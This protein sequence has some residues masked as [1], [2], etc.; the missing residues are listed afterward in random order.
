MRDCFV[1]QGGMAFQQIT[2]PQHAG[3]GKSPLVFAVS[4]EL[5]RAAM[6]CG[7]HRRL[8]DAI[9][10]YTIPRI[11]NNFNRIWVRKNGE[12]IPVVLT[13]QELGKLASG[14]GAEIADLTC[15]VLEAADDGLRVS[16]EK[17]DPESFSNAEIRKQI[18]DFSTGARDS[19][20]S[21]LYADINIENRT[22]LLCADEGGAP[23]YVEMPGGREFTK[24]ALAE[25]VFTSVAEMR[26]RVIQ[27]SLN[28]PNHTTFFALKNPLFKNESP[29]PAP[30]PLPAGL[31][32]VRE[33]KALQSWIFNGGTLDPRA[34]VVIRSLCKGDAII[35]LVQKES[36]PYKLPGLRD[37]LKAGIFGKLKILLG[38]ETIDG[39]PQK[40][41]RL[42]GLEQDPLSSSEN[43]LAVF[44]FPPDKD[45]GVR[46]MP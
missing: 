5:R 4:P 26:V 38:E 36:V 22:F 43:C 14:L 41:A 16:Q 35:T 25:V 17:T 42:F 8:L 6:G 15:F 9:D 28:Y 37:L 34:Q 1:G 31:S 29:S 23:V 13:W 20:P 32:R 7:I 12:R 46:L 44:L 27:R 24:Y 39:R 3:A 21:V 11:T 33:S 2:I 18:I 45:S 10:E 19:I 30:E 40:T